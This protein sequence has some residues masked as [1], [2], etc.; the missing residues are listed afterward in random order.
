M[1]QTVDDSVSSYG[2]AKF[3][4]WCLKWRKRLLQC[5]SDGCWVWDGYASHTNERCRGFKYAKLSAHFTTHG[6]TYKFS[7]AHRLSYF[8]FRGEIPGG[9]T[10][11]HTCHNSLCVNPY[12]LRLCTQAD[13]SSNHSPE[14]YAKQRARRKVAA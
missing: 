11:D 10:V 9:M 7:Y 6:R 14:W 3:A 4:K 8:L 2:D 12:H 1:T 13:N 5:K